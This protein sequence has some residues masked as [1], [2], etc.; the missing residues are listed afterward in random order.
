MLLS[1]SGPTD[2]CPHPLPAAR[3]HDRT[4]IPAKRGAKGSAT[5]TGAA[6]EML[7]QIW[8]CVKLSRAKPARVPSLPSVST[9]QTCN[10]S[11]SRL[12]LAKLVEVGIVSHF[13]VIHEAPRH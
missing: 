3:L 9:H 2:R 11:G 12:G 13:P 5:P 4:P 1:K 7:R 6:Y 8:S 10:R